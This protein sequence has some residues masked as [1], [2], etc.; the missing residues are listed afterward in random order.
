M[1]LLEFDVTGLVLAVP[2]IH[3][4]IAA[5]SGKASVPDGASLSQDWMETGDR[6]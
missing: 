3:D 2:D 6:R 4:A 5:S 1:L